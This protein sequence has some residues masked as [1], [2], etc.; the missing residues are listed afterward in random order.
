MD[1][2]DYRRKLLRNPKIKEEY[3]KR[4]TERMLTHNIIA[5]RIRKKMTQE[6]L[7]QK[8][9]ITQSAIARLENPA[10]GK[11]SISM[12]KK[13]ADALDCRLVVKLEPKKLTEKF[14]GN[15]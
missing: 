1:W 5:Q 13:I 7:A 4:Q 15:S 8:V 12:L 14:G 11:A 9:G 6:Q 3:E 2:Q 10:Y